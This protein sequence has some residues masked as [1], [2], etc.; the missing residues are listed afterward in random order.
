MKI[1]S[2]TLRLYPPAPVTDRGC[3]SDYTFPGTDV[4]IK[5][6]QNIGIPILGIHHDKRF[7]PN[8]EKF[9]PER[10]SPENRGNIIPYTFLAFGQGPRNCIGKQGGRPV[11]S[12]KC[13][14]YLLL[15]TFDFVGMRFAL[16]EVKLAIAQLVRHFTIE[17]SKR[18]LIPMVYQNA[19]SLK[20]KDG[21][22]LSLK[23]R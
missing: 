15:F 1:L 8:P 12:P 23:K 6:G 21:M 20:P 16:T 17:P 18:T 13:K 14:S 22:W 7:Y 9:D 5:A 4:T 11:S 19:G 2:E 10:F 3:T